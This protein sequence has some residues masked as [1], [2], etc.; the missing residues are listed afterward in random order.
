MIKKLT[1]NIVCLGLLWGCAGVKP[2]T[3]FENNTFSCDF[4][5]LKVQILN[6]VV[7]QTEKST[8]GQGYRRTIHSYRTGSDQFVGI[9]IWRF[10]HDSNKEWRSSNEQ[11]LRQIGGIP[12][13]PIAINNKTWVKF[14]QL[15]QKGYAAFGYFTRMDNNLVA[16]YSL[17]KVEQYKDDIESFAK[18]R[19]LS[20]Q[21]KRLID[22]TFSDIEKLFVIG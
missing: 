3:T 13:D 2:Q 7:R 4:P 22:K 17:I 8:P 21:L 20:E 1:L 11:L 10:G 19:V 16:A 5:K 6:N 9:T 18:T 12:L 15:T 14:V